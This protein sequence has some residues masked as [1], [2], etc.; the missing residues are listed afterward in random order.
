MENAFDLN[1]RHIHAISM[2]AKLGRINLAADRLGITQPALTQA[3]GKTELQLGT[4]LFTRNASGM[5]PTEA[6]Q[7]LLP[8]FDAAWQH[9]GLKA[10]SMATVR[11][12]A[13]VS[14]Y[15]SYTAASKAIGLSEPSLH[16][17]VQ[18]LSLNL[19]TS[20]VSRQGR[21]IMLT[22]A[23]HR[24]ARRFRL[25][26]SELEAGLS[27]LETLKG[28]SVGRIV[29]GA[30]PLSRATVLPQAV[31][32]FCKIHPHLEIAIIEGSYRELIELLRNGELDIMIGA[33]RNKAQ[34]PDIF[35]SPLF[36]DRPSVI[37]RAGHPLAGTDPTIEGLSQFDWI[38]AA[39]G[40]P[41]RENWEA[42]FQAAKFRRPA[43]AVQCGS[44]IAMRQILVDTNFLALMSPE[45]IEL[46]LKAGVL[47]E[48]RPLG[49][50]FVRSIGLSTRAGWQMSG[51]QAAFCEQLRQSAQ[52]HQIPEL[53]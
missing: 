21:G 11:A 12:L 6:L 36:N 50:E 49:D 32:A 38:M 17:A 30:M 7:T 31:S 5:T 10:I 8:R 51:L 24:F 15:G 18:N 23:G 34:E 28:Q 2:I 29:I 46:E 1:L 9:I 40:T 3:L 53:A 52:L 44:V 48:L 19:N 26:I 4:L 33:L 20:L 39:K 25:A 27:D 45:Q 14:T 35:Q 16:R 37:A 43:I 42:M 41:L 13:S 22:P 47:V